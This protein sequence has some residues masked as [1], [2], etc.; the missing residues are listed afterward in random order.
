MLKYEI[1]QAVVDRIKGAIESGE[2]VRVPLKSLET[3]SKI[4][5]QANIFEKA[6]SLKDAEPLRVVNDMGEKVGELFIKVKGELSDE[7]VSALPTQ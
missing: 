3:L 6:E 7:E 5:V 1:F 4:Y 2:E